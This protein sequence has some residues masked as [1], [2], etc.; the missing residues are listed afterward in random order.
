MSSKKW[1]VVYDEKVVKE[2]LPRVEENPQWEKRLKQIVAHIR[3]NPVA[4]GFDYEALRYDYS[5]Y[6]SR[7]LTKKHRIIYR[8][9]GNLVTIVQVLGHYRDR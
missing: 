3:A 1:D 9:E 5:G 6:H 8:I 4:P 2:Q 7:R